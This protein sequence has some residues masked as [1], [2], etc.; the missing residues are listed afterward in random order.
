M[1]DPQ[2]ISW[3]NGFKFWIAT[4]AFTHNLNELYGIDSIGKHSKLMSIKNQWYQKEKRF[5]DIFKYRWE[6][7]ESCHRIEL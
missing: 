5:Q 2:I 1:F 4:Q 6:N 3:K 7:Q